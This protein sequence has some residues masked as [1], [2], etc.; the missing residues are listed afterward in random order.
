MAMIP[1]SEA[2]GDLDEFSGSY[3]DDGKSV[4]WLFFCLFFEHM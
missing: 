3:N 4:E 2:M 1:P